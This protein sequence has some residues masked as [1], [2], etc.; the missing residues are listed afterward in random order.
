MQVLTM[1]EIAQV[2]GA[3][4]APVPTPTPTP[5]CGFFSFFSFLCAPFSCQ[6]T[7]TTCQPQPTSCQPKTSCQ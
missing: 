5:T 7:A 2:S 3:G 1:S 4:T 6:P